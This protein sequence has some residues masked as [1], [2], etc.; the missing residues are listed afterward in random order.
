MHFP[1][2]TC[3]FVGIV[4]CWLISHSY[5]SG[6]LVAITAKVSLAIYNVMGI[7]GKWLK[8]TITVDSICV[9]QA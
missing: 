5:G 3:H 9:N 7:M 2:R 1:G 6:S 8:D 4:M